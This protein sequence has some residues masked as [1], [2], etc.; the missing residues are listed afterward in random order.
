MEAEKGRESRSGRSSAKGAAA[1]GVVIA[2]HFN[3]PDTYVTKRPKGRDDWLITYTLGGRGYFVTSGEGRSCGEGDIVLLK[4]G[5]PHQY[6]TERGERWHFVWA[7]FS[8]RL[9]ETG[10]LPDKEL[11]VH[12][13]ESGSM[14][15]RIY[16]AFERVIA[17][18]SERGLYWH[19]LSENALREILLLLARR[20][21]RPID[22]RIEETLRLL[23][24]G[25]RDTVR[26][27]DLAKAVA[28]S[29]SRLSHLFKETTGRS[30]G[31]TLNAMRIRQ[32]ALLLAHTDRSASEVAFDVGFGN[33]NHFSNQFRKR[34]G[35]S[36]SAFQ[37][38]GIGSDST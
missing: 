15:K 24:E 31:E 30:I 25:M 37:K 32:A 21:S 1:S 20:M 3:E 33:Y 27:D 17:D 8:S 12:R 26:I 19:E 5:T 4:A 29:P 16:R 35:V 14:R 22:P 34:F 23:T 28:L 2:G 18:L 38:N 10:L 7:H 9:M 6:G 11:I 13:V 36:P